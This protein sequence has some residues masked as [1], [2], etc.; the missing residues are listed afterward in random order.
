MHTAQHITK[1]ALSGDLVDNR[2]I[3]L[4]THHISLCL[5]IATNLIELS[6]GTII[7]HG[8]IQELESQGQLK[9]LVETEDVVEEIQ[10]DP[11]VMPA[12]NEADVGNN[13]SVPRKSQ[14]GN[15]KLVDAEARAEGRVALSTYLTYIKATG[16]WSWILMVAFMISARLIDI[17]NQ[18]WVPFLV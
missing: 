17:G 16:T 13:D 14:T 5:P 4:V 3:I 2:T 11:A 9:Q 12:T 6:H 8:T 10:S 18:V 1:Y 7:R 15:G